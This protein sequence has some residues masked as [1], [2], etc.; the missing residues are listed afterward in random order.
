MQGYAA[1]N[2]GIALIQNGQEKEGILQMDELG[3]IRS[4]KNDVL[5]LRD[6]ANLTLGYRMLESGSPQLARKYLERVRLD[7]PYSN[8]ALLGLGWVNVSL[9]DFE[10]ALVPWSILHKRSEINESVQEAM[11]AVPYAYGKLEVHGKA[12][13]MYGKAMDVFGYEIDSLDKSIK[14]IREGKFLNAVL[15]E[16]A[17][18]D[19]NWL[20]NLRDLPDTPETHYLMELMASHDFQEGLK[21]YKD[22]GDLRKHL[23]I[24]LSGL[25]TFEEIIGIR[26]HYFEPLL[27]VVEKQFKKLDSRIKLRMEQRDRLDQRLKSMLIAR[28][29]EYLAT[30]EERD[31]QDR[32]A[33]I[34]VYLSA[35]PQYKT[36]EINARVSRLKGVVGWEVESEYDQR[37]TEAYKH[38][39]ELDE[40]IDKLKRIYQSF[41]R[42]RQAATQSYEGYDIPIR[43]LRTQIQATELKLK[44]IMARQGR[45][46]E[47]FAINELDK[48][49]QRLEEYQVKARFALA[50]SYDRATKKQQEELLQEQ[51][52]QVPVQEQATE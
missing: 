34:D 13:I 19:K 16:Q 30:A 18:R 29:P 43:Q 20:L 45:M 7:G 1:Y 41:I 23:A 25:D 32:L 37:L 6:K 9:G 44:G 35:N 3:Q 14:S 52:Q 10:T 11:L 42:T 40:H 49:R 4:G 51:Q 8:R 38:L 50:E 15:S 26:R 24:W 39:H 31:A 36:D 12:A 46:L 2:L 47:Q 22:L 17:E 5:A 27:P 48:R 33:R 21:N 28:R